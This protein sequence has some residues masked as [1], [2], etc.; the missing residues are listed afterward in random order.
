MFSNA[1][2]LGV[3][4]VIGGA[5]ESSAGR[6][7]RSMGQHMD[8]LGKSIERGERR[9]RRFERAKGD[10]GRRIRLTGDATGK[11]AAKH[12]FLGGAIDRTRRKLDRYRDSLRGARKD[13]GRAQQ[14]E[15]ARARLGRTWAAAGAAVGGVY[16]AGRVVG[17]ALEHEE[18]AVRLRTVLVADD[19]A[20]EAELGRALGHAREL[21][22]SRG[23]LHG[24]TELLGINYALGSAGF[25]AAAARAGAAV[26]SKVATVTGGS[27]EQTAEV[28]ATAFNN[29]GGTLEGTDAERLAQAGDI[30]AK[31]QFKYSIRDFGQLGEGISTAVSAAKI[32]GLGFAETAVAI[33][34]F[35]DAG[36]KGS[37]AGTALDAV[38]RQLDPAADEL[39]FGIAETADGGLDLVATLEGLDAAL[40][41]RGG[42][43]RAR[44]RAIQDAFGDEGK[45]VVNLLDKLPELRRHIEEV[46][47]AGTV[48]DAFIL[49]RDSGFGAVKALQNNAAVLRNVLGQAP[50]TREWAGWAADRVAQ[51]GEAVEKSEAL[52]KGLV[53][54]GMAAIGFSA[55]SVGVAAVRFAWAQLKSVV[56]GVGRVIAR[57]TGLQW[58]YNAA[59]R[60]GSLGGMAPRTGRGRL[61]AAGRGAGR[62]LSRLGAAVGR[63]GAVLGAA[64]GRGVVRMGGA[65]KTL[66]R[67]AAVVVGLVGFKVLA[68]GALIGGAA[69]LV[70]KYWEPIKGFFTRLWAGVVEVAKTARA[71]VTATLEPVVE[72]FGRVF[73]DFTAT[74]GSVVGAW[75]KVF[76]DFSWANV[77]SAVMKTL[78]AGIKA[79][80]GMPVRAFLAVLQKLRDYLPFSD[81]R[82]G[83]LSKLTASGASMLRTVGDG[84]RKA[85]PNGLRRPLARELAAASTALALAPAVLGAA[86]PV[87]AAR[88]PAAA[89]T[90]PAA[91]DQSRIYV[92]IHQQP[93]ED[94]AAL[95]DRLLAEIERRRGVR[96]RAALHDDY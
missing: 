23:T 28:V 71:G 38:L 21:V 34:V 86:A 73:T 47:A 42:G 80:G 18:A 50:A 19:D 54:A 33:G 63:S 96:R 95:V 10:L 64:T 22:R 92:T 14:I 52:Q 11:L 30:L 45:A 35:N 76:A 15:H 51:I 8:R 40:E 20:V 87:P 91:V 6:S 31:T 83:P 2:S 75:G 70:V 65:L 94:A 1:A 61:R 82:T 27:A 62:G 36:K 48:D 17:G 85:G 78:A 41:R 60:A 59:V 9:I 58:A 74:L 39:G 25:D 72:F 29:L 77:G 68:I 13:I 88:P 55:A 90:A 57:A 7:V 32:A 81:A 84:V 66:G 37:E 5:L 79:A 12:D 3:G 89:R 53:G 46:T 44:S 43:A 16:A 4:V 26:V 69:Y 49:H 24:E 93:R 56:M 67:V